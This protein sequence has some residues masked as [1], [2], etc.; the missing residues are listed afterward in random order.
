MFERFL[1]F[2]GR[3]PGGTR[4]ADASADD[5]RVAAAALLFSVIDADGVRGSA[6]L[7]ELRD[8]LAKAFQITGS[9]LDALIAAGDEAERRSVDFHAFT[10]VLL[11]HLDEDGRKAFVESLWE[12]VYADGDRSELEDNVVWRIAELIGIGATERNDIRRRVER[13]ARAADAPDR[14]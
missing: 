2:L 8:G 12:I 1:A 14:R 7:D 9:R 10:R 4:P 13:A 3:L 5:P 11:R 6:E